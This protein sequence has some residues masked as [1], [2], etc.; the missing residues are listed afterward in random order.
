M[1]TIPTVKLPHLMPTVRF[2]YPDLAL[3]PIVVCASH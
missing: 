1:R 3:S 2:I